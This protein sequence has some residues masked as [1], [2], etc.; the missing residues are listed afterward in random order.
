MESAIQQVGFD[1]VIPESK[2][3]TVSD[4]MTLANPLYLQT[5]DTS[6]RFREDMADPNFKWS[7]NMGTWNSFT[8]DEKAVALDALSLDHASVLLDRYRA[9]KNALEAID[10][11]PAWVKYPG[12]IVAGVT[13]PINFVPVAGSSAKLWNASKTLG[14]MAEVGLKVGT[15]G[16]VSNVASEGLFDIQGMNSDYPS[17]A[18]FGFVLGGSIGAIGEG[19][20]RTRFQREFAASLQSRETEINM[21][22]DNYVWSTEPTTFGEV[23]RMKFTTEPPKVESVSSLL[24]PSILK[25]DTMKLW[26]H[27]TPEVRSYISRLVAPSVAPKDANG[28]VI[29]VPTTAADKKVQWMGDLNKARVELATIHRDAKVDGGWRGSLEDFQN[30]VVNALR[31]AAIEQENRVYAHVSQRDYT[32]YKTESVR[33]IEGNIVVTKQVIDTEATA[34]ARQ[35]AVIKTYAE[36]TTPLTHPNKYIQKAMEVQRAYYNKMLS[37]GQDLKVKGLEGISTNKIYLPRIYDFQ[38]IGKMDPDVLKAKLK[39]AY[40]THPANPR[41][42]DKDLNILVQDLAEKFKSVSYDRG[43]LD[44]S[45]VVPKELPLGTH[46]KAQKIKL[47]DAA[48]DDILLKNGEDI[49]GL[50]HYKTSGQYAVQWAFGTTDLDEIRNTHIKPIK[51]KLGD[52]VGEVSA[53]LDRVLQDTIGTLRIPKNGDSFGWKTSRLLSHWNASTFGGSFGLN[54]LTEIPAAAVAT[55]YKAAFINNLGDAIKGVHSLLFK[56]KKADMEWVNQILSMGHMHEVMNMQGINRLAE[57][58]NIVSAGWLEN[59]AMG[60]TDKL[61]KWNGMR[62]ITA[63]LEAIVGANAIQDIAK[64]AAKATPSNTE[65]TRLARWGITKND[66]SRL[67]KTMKKYVEY[68]AKGGLKDLN[69]N[70]W[71]ADDLDMIQTAVNR[72]IQSGVVQGDTYH[73]P[74]WMIVPDPVR[75]LVFQ[76]LR[77]PVAAHEILLRRGWQ[78]DKAGLV[79]S[80]LGAMMAYGAMTYLREQAT[81]AAGLKEDYDA[82]YDVFNDDEAWLRLVGKSSNYMAATGALTLPINYGLTLAGMPELGRDYANDPTDILGPTVGRIGDVNAVLKPLF[83]EGQ[84]DNASQWYAVKNMTPMMNVPILSEGLSAIIQDQGY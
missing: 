25:S 76:F 14:R 1:L 74:S 10:E 50:Y 78:E 2:D 66:A 83:T 19:I 72:A 59:K 60:F 46:L 65:L 28:N 58:E 31:E 47:N 68:N 26:E 9:Q 84:W 6:T 61:F 63:T 64:I 52:R 22:Q 49:M 42:S 30:A 3:S 16:A 53:E 71:P 81:I 56:G 67:A 34:K 20:S 69:L 17:A 55:G 75:R 18:L 11:D 54:T 62:G 35:E 82:K 48:L 27:D 57:T 43:F 5:T 4:Y 13:D 24:H 21:A 70:K 44:F 23:P 7:D 32:V 29:A 12:L 79:A 77:F 8:D 38:T 41:L 45:Y 33:D 36:D 40:K 39:E 73:L 80:A 37:R 15:V 51:D